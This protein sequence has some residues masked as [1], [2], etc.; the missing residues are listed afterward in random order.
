LVPS[1]FIINSPGSINTTTFSGTT[2]VQVT[3]ALLTPGTLT[4]AGNQPLRPG[5]GPFNISL[6]LTGGTPGTLTPTTLTFNGGDS[7]KNSSFQPSNAGTAT[8]NLGPQPVGFSTSLN[9]QQIS[10]AVTAPAINVAANVSVGLNLQISVTIFL[11]NVPPNPITL[12]VTS[13]NSSIATVTTNPAVA[14]GATATFTNVTS[15]FVGTLTVQGISQNTTQLKLQA[16][17]YSDAF[18]NVTVNPSGFIINTPSNFTASVGSSTA[19]QITPA[20][21]D[22]ATLNYAGNQTLRAGLTANVGVTSSNTTVGTI[23]TSPLAFAGNST[24]ASTLFQALT[25]G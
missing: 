13:P 19:I 15:T 16:P 24:F 25:P 6:A 11:Q 8:I 9:F 22:P 2:Q 14:G 21:L 20:M 7:F 3:S 12:T 10:V 5:I 4:W 1:G 17:G 23:A 18:V